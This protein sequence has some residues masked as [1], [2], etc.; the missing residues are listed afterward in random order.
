MLQRIARLHSMLVEWDVILFVMDAD[1]LTAWDS[2]LQ[3]LCALAEVR[4]A[5]HEHVKSAGLDLPIPRL[6]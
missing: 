5:A 1:W 6:I 4:E 3:F 2:V